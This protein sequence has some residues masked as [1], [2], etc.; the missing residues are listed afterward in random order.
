[1][2]DSL[3]RLQER[4]NNCHKDFRLISSRCKYASL[5]GSFGSGYECIHPYHK[6]SKNRPQ[7]CTIEKCIV[8]NKIA[9]Y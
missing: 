9:E 4:I 3:A 1:M 8:V 5:D 2:K 7:Q 6:A